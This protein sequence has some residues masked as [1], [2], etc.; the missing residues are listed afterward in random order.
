MKRLLLVFIFISN[1]SFAQFFTHQDAEQE[2][3]YTVSPDPEMGVNADG[4]DDE[5]PPADEEAPIDDYLIYL[6]VLGVLIGIMVHKPK[7]KMRV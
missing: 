7:T 2:S 6:T 4:D 3:H 5:P 1:L